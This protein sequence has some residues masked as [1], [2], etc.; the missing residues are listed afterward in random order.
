[1]TAETLWEEVCKGFCPDSQDK[2]ITKD[3]LLK[4]CED[5]PIF[6]HRGE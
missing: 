5:C 6:M 2:N 1:M 3:E 4:I